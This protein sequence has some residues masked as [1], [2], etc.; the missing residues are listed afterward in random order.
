MT[1]IKQMPKEEGIDHSLSLL[2]EGYLY[3][4]NRCHSFQSN[5]FETR[6]FGHK[7]I[8]MRGIEAAEL[9][10]DNEKFQRQ[11]PVSSR[12]VRTLFGKGSVLELDG[13]NHSH[14]KQLFMSVM[15]HERLAQLID[16]VEQHWEAAISEWEQK[17]EIVFYEE[18]KKM[19]CKVA[20]QWASVPL[21]EDELGRWTSDLAAVYESVGTFSPDRLFGLN[22]QK[23]SEKRVGELIDQ[24]RQE[25]VNVAEDTILHRFVWHHDHNGN[26]I[27]RNTAAIEIINVLRPI[28]AISLYINFILLSLHHYPEEKQKIVANGEAYAQMFVNEVRRFYPY[29]PFAGA[30]VKTNFMWN[31]YFFEEGSLSLLDLYGTNHD[32]S[33]WKDPETFRPD[34]FEQEDIHSFAFIPQGGGDYFLGHRCAGEWLTV[35]VMKASLNT[36]LH[37]MSY[38]VPNQDLSYSMVHIP[39]IPNSKIVLKNIKRL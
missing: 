13:E 9:F 3:I 4:S 37:K 21:S 22:A 34:R 35:E 20:F 28:I 25:E 32:A 7:A 29:F 6:L 36:L 18:V 2:R 8:C 38:E 19:L 14:R 27:D 17:D 39:T 23:R 26:L 30:T 33:V 31:G 5:F 1:T 12:A 11:G 15:T 16:L 10:Y 24:V